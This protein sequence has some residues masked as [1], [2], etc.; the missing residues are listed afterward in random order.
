MNKEQKE[1][2]EAKYKIAE[3]NMKSYQLWENYR[4]DKAKNPFEA[5]QEFKRWRPKR[6]VVVKEYLDAK[7]L[8]MKARTK[9]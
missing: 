6:H 3:M 1:E 2:V 8:L 4:W 7:E 5:W 9:E